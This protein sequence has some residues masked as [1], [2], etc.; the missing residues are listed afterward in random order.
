MTS[1]STF[2]IEYFDGTQM[3]REDDWDWDTVC[4]LILDLILVYKRENFFWVTLDL[5]D[6]TKQ[7]EYFLDTCDHFWSKQYFW[8]CWSV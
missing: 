5:Q 7:D 6:W 4:I 8:V 2:E 1:W 3:I